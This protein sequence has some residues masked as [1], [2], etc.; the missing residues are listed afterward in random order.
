MKYWWAGLLVF[1]LF[2]SLNG[3]IFALRKKPKLSYAIAWS[4][5]AFLLLYKIGEY[6][7]WQAVGQHMKFPVEFSAL[8]YFIFGITVTFRL[9]KAE[10]FGAFVG[11]LAGLMYSVSFWVS[12]GSLIGDIDTPFLFAMAIFNHHALY[13]ASMLLLANVHK[14]NYKDCWIQLVGVGAMVGYSWL[15]YLFTPYAEIYGKPIIIQI[16][17]GSILNWLGGLKLN[18]WQIALYIIVAL[19]LLAGIL[20]GFYSLNNLCAK[21]RAANNIEIDYHPKKLID[22]F[23]I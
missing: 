7:Y 6:V 11:V 10:Q 14:F 19:L 2:V 17:D 1:L 22:I 23:H 21:K 15:I 3:I 13:F 9:K 8:S 16:C 18:G 20:F 12:P 5:A 4:I